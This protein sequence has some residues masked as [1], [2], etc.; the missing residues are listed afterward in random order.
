M[1]LVEA[2]KSSTGRAQR[3]VI[4]GSQLHFLTILRRPD[5][6]RL[7]R[8]ILNT[9]GGAFESE[10]IWDFCYLT[11]L[12]SA[13]KS[14]GFFN[15]IAPNAS[16]WVGSVEAAQSEENGED[17]EYD[18]NEIIYYNPKER[19]SN[20]ANEEDLYDFLE[21]FE[22][23]VGTDDIEIDVTHNHRVYFDEIY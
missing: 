5:G 23:P 9:V 16:D 11:D 21:K 6:Y 22:H 7:L 18:E 19:S 3:Q 4:V 1:F 8:S 10:K 12:V 2:L 15:E 14:G 20:Y 13:A 17:D